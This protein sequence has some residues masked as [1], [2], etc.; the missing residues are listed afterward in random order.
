MIHEIDDPIVT[1]PTVESGDSDIADI[2]IIDVEDEESN[3]SDADFSGFSEAE[4]DFDLSEDKLEETLVNGE[5]LW[6]DKSTHSVYDLRGGLSRFVGFM[7]E[8]GSLDTSGLS[9]S[10]D[11]DENTILEDRDVI[12]EMARMFSPEEESDSESNLVE[13]VRQSLLKRAREGDKVG[14]MGPKAV[15]KAIRV[16]SYE[17][18]ELVLI[19]LVWSCVMW[20]I[21]RYTEI[22]AKFLT[23][24]WVVMGVFRYVAL[25][26]VFTRISN[27]N[28][29]MCYFFVYCFAAFRF[30]GLL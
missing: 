11:R 30:S 8:D 2:D 10:S 15:E 26:A 5:R 7:N 22:G 28:L 27:I 21:V 16:A 14:T 13:E 18:T 1:K 25:K 4:D 23:L 24:P 6:I 19:L 9:V 17:Y 3:P 20:G 12:D 29:F